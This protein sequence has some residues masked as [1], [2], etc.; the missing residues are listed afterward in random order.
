MKLK[1]SNRARKIKYLSV[2]T[3]Y[4]N[5]GRDF[6]SYMKLGRVFDALYS[7]FNQ[8]QTVYRNAYTMVDVL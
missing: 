8:M 4:F 6:N 3:S 2:R 7:G 1:S 5:F